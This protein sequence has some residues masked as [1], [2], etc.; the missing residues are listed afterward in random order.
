M[1]NKKN[2]NNEFLDL[3]NLINKCKKKFLII[4]IILFFI[5]SAF[6]SNIKPEQIGSISLDPA[7]VAKSKLYETPEH[8]FKELDLSILRS[9]SILQK[10]NTGNFKIS[11]D[12]KFINVSYK[13]R[14]KEEIYECLTNVEK[15]I[16]NKEYAKFSY[17]M[18]LID[19]TLDFYKGLYSQN[20]Q[21]KSEFKSSEIET[22]IMELS[23]LKKSKFDTHQTQRI[24]SIQITNIQ[25]YPRLIIIIIIL[26]LSLMLSIIVELFQS[27]KHSQS[28]LK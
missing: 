20:I 28:T 4:S 13:S 15:Y 6:I 26:L 5:N 19:E 21:N 14:E 8:A 27:Y 7:T 17:A 3:F 2:I 16:Q 11:V 22:N 9:E 24:G 1:E 25:H 18:H 12:E 10:C 23:T